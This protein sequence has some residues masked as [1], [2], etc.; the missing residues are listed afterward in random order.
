MSHNTWIHR[1]VRLG[2]RP[3]AHT[4]LTPN[5]VTTMRLA[6]GVAAAAAYAAGTADGYFWGGVLFVASI[7][8]DRADGEL[9]RLGGKATPWGHTYDLCVDALCNAI[10][11]LGLGW[12]LRDGALGLWAPA[13]GALAGLSVAAILFMTLKTEALGGQRAGEIKG[14]AGFD[15]DDAIAVVPV[16]VWLG[17]PRELLIAAAIGAPAFALFALALLR[18]RQKRLRSR[19]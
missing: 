16:V 4:R 2:V 11:F 17:W 5:H 15:P 7:L 6:T 14:V 3:L 10:I 13:M 1:F 18:R 8:L 19:A 12:G 9:A